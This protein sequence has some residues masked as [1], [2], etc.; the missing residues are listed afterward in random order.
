MAIEEGQ[1]VKEIRFSTQIEDD[2]IIRPPRDAGLT[3]GEAEVIVWQPTAS[4]ESVHAS[5]SSTPQPATGTAEESTVGTGLPPLS[6]DALRGRLARAAEELG[7]LDLP[8][9]LAE[10]HDHYAHGAPKG[11]DRR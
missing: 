8:A 6:F 1:A 3:P 10:N 9:D 4:D 7:I 2:R 5:E 11:I